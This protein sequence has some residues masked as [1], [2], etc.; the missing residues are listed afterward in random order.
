[1]NANT[2]SEFADSTKLEIAVGPL[3]FSELFFEVSLME[4]SRSNNQ[5]MRR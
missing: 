1:M 2:Y 4:I 5:M 3:V